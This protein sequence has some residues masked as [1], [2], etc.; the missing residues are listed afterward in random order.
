MTNH[1]TP[2]PRHPGQDGRRDTK[3][4]LR[5]TDPDR[6]WDALKGRK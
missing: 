6:R 5:K 1:T 3:R 4:A 2:T